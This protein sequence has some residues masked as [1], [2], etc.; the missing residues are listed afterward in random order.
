[1]GFNCIQ[2]GEREIWTHETL[3]HLC[4]DCFLKQSN[5]QDKYP[6][7]PLALQRQSAW[8]VVHNPHIYT[9]PD[10]RTFMQEQLRTWPS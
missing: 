10:I 8:I 1:M 9:D 7:M 2:C 5:W 6:A 4:L 3:P